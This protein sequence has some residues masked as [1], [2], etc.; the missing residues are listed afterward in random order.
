MVLT[1]MTEDM[2]R[3]LAAG[4]AP[5]DLVPE[6][7]RRIAHVEA[8]RVQVRRL[9]ED[10]R[11]AEARHADALAAI[12]AELAEWQ[13]QCPHPCHTFGAA[14]TVCGLVRAGSST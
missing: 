11:R 14:C 4:I 6:L 9:D 10:R 8:V 13:A 3:E 1:S 5:A 7:A 2:L 12:A